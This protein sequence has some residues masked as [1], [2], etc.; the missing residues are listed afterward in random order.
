MALSSRT[1]P[2][3]SQAAQ[4][5]LKEQN[6]TISLPISEQVSAEVIRWQLETTNQLLDIEMRLGGYER[7]WNSKNNDFEYK[8]KHDALM[9]EKGISRIMS[10]LYTVMN[11]NTI[12][13]DYKKE[14]AYKV[15]IHV[16]NTVIDILRMNRAAFAVNKTDLPVIVAI[17]ENGIKPTL[18][19]GVDAMTMDA[20]RGTSVNRTLV[21]QNP[22]SGGFKRIIG[23]LF[24]K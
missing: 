19:R 14:E 21:V 6:D 17:V 22:Q 7:V 24:G 4:S 13:S 1:D 8:K 10:I 11:V 18:F 16:G 9:N 23:G 3:Y 12:L 5:E 20:L 2:I 15:I